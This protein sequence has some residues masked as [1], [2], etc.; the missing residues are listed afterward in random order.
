MDEGGYC[1]FSA[2]EN[3]AARA[4]V[5]CAK[6]RRAIECFESPDKNSENLANEGRRIERVPGGYLV[7]NAG[8]YRAKFSREI[9]KE[10]TRIRVARYRAKLSVR[11]VENDECNKSTVTEALHTV[12]P[13]SASDSVQSIKKKGESEGKPKVL[14]DSEWVA[15]PNP[16]RGNQD[17]IPKT[18]E[19]ERIA[20]IFHRKPSTSW[21]DKEQRGWR[22]HRA[23][24]PLD[25]DELCMIERR[26][27]KEWPP[28]RDKNTLRHDLF[29]LLNNYAAEADRARAWCSE[30]LVKS[31][32]VKFQVVR[33]KSPDWTPEQIADNKRK[34]RAL[35]DELMEKLKAPASS[36]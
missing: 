20:A 35:K 26:Y 33:T 9:E 25:D 29:T 6:A 23:H 14:V 16:Q 4:H 1:H 30:H 13:A 11:E 12:S 15:R 5:S 24:G 2:L 19:A 34:C 31:K 17:A 32:S 3:L 7:L 21:S 27:A 28:N 36:I 18:K 10:Q 22:N 8:Y